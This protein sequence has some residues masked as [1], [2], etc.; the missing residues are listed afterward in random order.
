MRVPGLERFRAA[1]EWLDR[2]ATVKE[3]ARP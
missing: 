1:Q 3:S 2:N